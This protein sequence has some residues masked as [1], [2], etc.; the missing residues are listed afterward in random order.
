MVRSRTRETMFEELKKVPDPRI[1][2]E[3]QF[4]HEEAVDS[5]GP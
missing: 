4:Y 2:F 3:I 1:T 5:G